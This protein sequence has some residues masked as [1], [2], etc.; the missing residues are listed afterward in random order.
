MAFSSIAFGEFMTTAPKRARPWSPSGLF[1]EPAR[2]KKLRLKNFPGEELLN[3]AVRTYRVYRRTVVEI[4]DIVVECYERIEALE[5][6]EVHNSKTEFCRRLGCTLTH[7][8]RIV[9]EAR[10]PQSK[11]LHKQPTGF[12]VTEAVSDFQPDEEYAERELQRI[13]K[14]LQPLR[15]LSWR[16]YQNVC[17]MLAKGLAEASETNNVDGKE[18]R[19]A[20]D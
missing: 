3:L 2:D 6:P 19:S 12:E 17:G 14:N 5:F 13:F 8:G 18:L 9:R 11:R 15:E 10:G 4:T 16:R 7:A 20:A 1:H